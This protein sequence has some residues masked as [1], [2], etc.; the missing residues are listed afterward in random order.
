MKKIKQVRI[1]INENKLNRLENIK[2]SHLIND[3]LD[4]YIKLENNKKP[5]LIKIEE[6][7]KQGL[8]IR[9]QEWNFLINMI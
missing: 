2:L 9:N 7:I 3:L 5:N 6:K 4:V 1:N 8:Y